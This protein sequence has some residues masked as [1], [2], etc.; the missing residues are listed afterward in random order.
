MNR[1]LN[2]KMLELKCFVDNILTDI[3]LFTDDQKIELCDRLSLLCSE[4]H[5]TIDGSNLNNNCFLQDNLL[6]F[7]SKPKDSVISVLDC[8]ILSQL[9]KEF[10]KII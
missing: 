10:E 4:L 1:E 8:S 7:K 6:F 3:T 2:E 9:S 5:N